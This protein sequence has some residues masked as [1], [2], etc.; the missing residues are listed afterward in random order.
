MTQAQWQRLTGANPSGFGGPSEGNCDPAWLL[1]P[2]EQVSSLDCADLMKHLGLVLPTESEWEYGAR[3]RTASVWWTGGTRTTLAG[4]ENVADKSSKGVAQPLEDWLDDGARV[5]AQIG[6][7]RPNRF[8]LYDVSG[9]VSEWC[10][11]GFGGYTGP[12]P[13]RTYAR[14]TAV[15]RGGDYMHDASRARSASRGSAEPG[16]RRLDIGVRPARFLFP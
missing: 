5:H 8:G 16:S 1:H 9:N 12:V 15:V 2:V 13:D 3:A 6:S 7:Y 11:D 10:R 14:W 4:A